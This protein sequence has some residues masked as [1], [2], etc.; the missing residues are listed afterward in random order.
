MAYKNYNAGI[1]SGVVSANKPKFDWIA[2]LIWI[3]SLVVSLVPIYLL[4]VQ[5]LIESNGELK[6]EFWFNCFKDYDV[7]WV[8]ATLLLFSCVSP[9][10]NV[11]KISKSGKHPKNSITALIIVGFVVFVFIEALWLVFKYLLQEYQAWPIYLGTGF[12]ILSLIIA[13]PLQINF[14]LNEE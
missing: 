7:L 6:A 8:F 4:L 11:R 9:I 3:V 14:I 13:T 12:I 1:K 5:H 10:T 2:F